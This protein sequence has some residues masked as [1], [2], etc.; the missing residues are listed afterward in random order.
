[1]PVDALQLESQ[2]PAVLHLRAKL[3]RRA[4]CTT[5]CSVTSPPL[6]AAILVVGYA[7]STD[8]DMRSRAYA[9]ITLDFS[10][11]STD[12]LTT[13]RGGRGNADF[14]PLAQLT[15]SSSA[16]EQGTLQQLWPLLDGPLPV[17]PVNNFIDLSGAAKA[18]LDAEQLEF[19]SNAFSD[20]LG[21]LISLG[22]LQ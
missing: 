9:A 16:G 14:S 15:N 8:Y 10:A 1:M 20:R 18:R 3:K 11:F 2:L 7:L 6:F 21:N 4:C 13:F 19:V 17:V 22:T 5:C 12:L